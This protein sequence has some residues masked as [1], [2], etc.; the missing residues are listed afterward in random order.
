MA[1]QRI[2]FTLLRLVERGSIKL[3][4]QIAPATDTVT[5]LIKPLTI[6]PIVGNLNL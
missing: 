2:V 1:E 3:T 6:L 5:F 4:S